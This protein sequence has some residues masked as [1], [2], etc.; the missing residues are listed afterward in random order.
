MWIRLHEPC[1]DDYSD[2]ALS[3]IKEVDS[4]SDCYSVEYFDF[5]L[6]KSTLVS[7]VDDPS[8]VVCL[9]NGEAVRGSESVW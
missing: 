7:I 1:P 6:A 2:E 8:I 9:S 3:L 4:S 5:G